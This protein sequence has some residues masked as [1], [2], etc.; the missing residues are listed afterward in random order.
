MQISIKKIVGSKIF[1]I[2]LL[3]L[4]LVLV[5]LSIFLLN[6]KTLKEGF[7]A[8]PNDKSPYRYYIW[9]ISHNKYTE[10]PGNI[11]NFT[12]DS[13]DNR[14]EVDQVRFYS[15]LPDSSGVDETIGDIATS[16]YTNTSSSSGPIQYD[17]S[18]NVFSSLPNT[19]YSDIYGPSQ[20][21]MSDSSPR[22]T[23][24]GTQTFIHD[25][26]GGYIIFDFG[27]NY[28]TKARPLGF[29]WSPTNNINRSPAIWDLLVT[30]NITDFPS[31]INNLIN[32]HSNTTVPTNP[33][34]STVYN[35][36]FPT[37]LPQ[38]PAPP[39][40][41]SD[42][43]TS[44]PPPPSSDTNT[45]PPP[46]PP[47]SGTN[48]SPP[49][50]SGTNTSPPPPPPSSGTNTSPPPSSGTNT[51]PPPSS[52]TNTSPPPGTNTSP[53]P[54]TNT[55]PPSTS[56]FT[57][58]ALHS[59]PIPGIGNFGVHHYNGNG[60][61]ISQKGG[62]GGNNYFTPK[63]YIKKKKDNLQNGGFFQD[64]YGYSVANYGINA[65][66]YLNPENQF[67]ANYPANQYSRDFNVNSDICLDCVDEEGTPVIDY[68]DPST[69]DDYD[70]NTP[71]IRSV[72]EAKLYNGNT[73]SCKMKKFHPGYEL[74][75]PTCWDVPQK[76]PP[77]CLSDKK[78]LP[79][80]V[81]DTGASLN[82]LDLN[83]SIGSIMP[84]FTYIEHP[85]S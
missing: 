40:P 76:R 55:S 80:A 26:P 69:N 75:P 84:G 46:P 42:T 18:A 45:S 57:P 48:T 43:N 9:Y 21:F 8:V 29:S 60:I 12:Y 53:P 15:K 49:P 22:P 1:W 77:V 64:V 23:I 58:P 47:S 10:N 30:N 71:D 28:Y 11:T 72:Q 19:I 56:T 32:I 24:Q 36:S 83:T 41:S 33:S 14:L 85:R 78:C 44:P 25:K 50:S 73:H 38:M 68:F 20:S 27:E 17:T 67:P 62:G 66:P 5:I 16:M 54:G 63:I 13:P 39:P 82:A 59:T 35:F 74:Q 3:L 52:G 6:K 7:E 61:N 4:S 34:L 79:A 81:F 51:S 65:N 37:D 31:K 2:T 70:D